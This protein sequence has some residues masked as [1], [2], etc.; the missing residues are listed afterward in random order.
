MTTPAKKNAKSSKKRTSSKKRKG[1]RTSH[2]EERA[3]SS[4]PSPW[5]QVVVDVNDMLTEAITSTLLEAGALGVEVHDD[6][7][8]SMPGRLAQLTGKTTVVAPFSRVRGLEARVTGALTHVVSFFEDAGDME[9]AWSDLFAED[10]N[11]AF[12]KEWRPL[13]IS[14]RVWIV[15]SWDRADFVV[16]DGAVALYLDPGLAFGTGTHETTRLCARAIDEVCAQGVPTSVLD[17]GTGTGILALAALALGVPRAVGTDID[18]VAVK[19]ALDNAR[20]NALES[21]FTALESAPDVHGLHPLVVANILAEPLILL[22]PRIARTL[23]PGGRLFLSG[24]LVDQARAVREAYVNQG[25]LDAG[26]A[27]ENGWMRLDF[28]AHPNARAHG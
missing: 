27:E 19:A 25:L 6:T 10:W 5:R 12:K 16:P 28:V 1:A 21:R 3:L 11:A 14:A 20:E 23:A 15:P 13:T 2:D 26:S 4:A 22:A 8:R 17:V 7:T 9:I 18:P 24:L